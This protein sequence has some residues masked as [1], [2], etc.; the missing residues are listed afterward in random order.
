MSC[1][2]KNLFGEERKGAHSYRF[3]DFAV[4]DTV[5]TFIA[6]GL[7]A[8]VLRTPYW[9]TLLVLFLTGIVLHR[10]FCVETTID[11]LLFKT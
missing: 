6:A 1:P 2:Y 9:P 3:M 7:L 10:A 11:R 8:W 5:L 4:V